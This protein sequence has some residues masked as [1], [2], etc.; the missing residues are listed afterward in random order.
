VLDR[1]VLQRHEFHR[2]RSFQWGVAAEGTECGAVREVKVGKVEAVSGVAAGQVRD[3]EIGK[4]GAAGVRVRI[5]V[6]AMRG[7]SCGRGG[8]HGSS[9]AGGSEDRLC[10]REGLG[11]TV[12]GELLSLERRDERARKTVQRRGAYLEVGVGNQTS[13]SVR[14][15]HLA[16]LRKASDKTLI[17]TEKRRGIPQ[18]GGRRAAGT[19]EKQQ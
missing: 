8:R 6:R 14:A 12:L 18:P 16:K 15:A 17:D 13:Q 11:S 3:R 10:Q 5:R 2:R 4:N 9:A 7:S 19:R 1:P